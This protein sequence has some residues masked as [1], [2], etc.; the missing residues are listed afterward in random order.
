MR[1]VRSGGAVATPV[2]TRAL[3][4]V[5]VVVWLY[6]LANGATAGEA[7][8]STFVR[9]ALYGPSVGIDHEWY[10]LITGGFMHS[11]LPH[12]GLN[13]W[14]LWLLGPQLEAV[15]GRVRFALIYAAGL[16]AGSAGVMVLS[17][18]QP[19]V[20]ASGAIFGLFGAAFIMQRSMGIDPFRSGLARIIGINLVITLLLPGIS[21]GGHL[22]GLAGGALVGWI[23][24]EGPRRLGSKAATYAAASGVIVLYFVIAVAKAST[25]TYSG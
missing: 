6:S 20:G 22:G 15:L 19:T 5:N 3:V 14:A 7:G 4:A 10:R 11:G 18:H 21:K 17:P 9:F 2:I 25:I 1:S 24:L 12:I 8:G 16:I 23:V 13:M